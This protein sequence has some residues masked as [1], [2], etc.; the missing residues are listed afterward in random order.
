VAYPIVNREPAENRLADVGSQPK[1]R[2]S[3]NLSTFYFI[4]LLGVCAALLA[5]IGDAVLS[6]S[7]KPVWSAE[8]RR[9][10][11]VE[12]SDRRVETLPFVGQER[13]GVA[14]PAADEVLEPES[15][16]A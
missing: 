12:T 16:S 9:L 5:L 13:R 6:V 15:L 2:R 11:L 1:I 3:L 14:A 4:A 10:E 7:R 8:R